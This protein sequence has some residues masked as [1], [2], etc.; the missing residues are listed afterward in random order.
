MS[1]E[2]PRVLASEWGCIL[3]SGESCLMRSC[4][5]VAG[6]S[7]LRRGA[8]WLLGVML[9]SCALLLALWG[10]RMEGSVA[11]EGT[12]PLAGAA[13]GDTS[14]ATDAGS[15]TLAVQ[16]GTAVSHTIFLPILYRPGSLPF[17]VQVNHIESRTTSAAADA[18]A[19]WVRLRLYWDAIEPVNTTPEH[20][21]WSPGL[22]QEL[23]TY[24]ARN[25]NVVLTLAHNPDWAATY[26]AG[27]I[28]LVPIDELVQFM[29]AVVARYGA[30]PY[31]VKHWE[32]YNEP[33]NGD[34]YR[35]E[36]GGWGYFG[37]DPQ[38]YVDL[39]EA[40]Y[41]PVKDVDPEAQVLF[42]GMA[43]DYWEPDGP[44]VKTFFDEVLGIMQDSTSYPFDVMNFHYYP[45]FAV[46]WEAYGADII[47]KTN[48][49]RAKMLE[50]GADKPLVCT[51]T[52]MWSN[53]LDEDF[54]LVCGSDEKQSRYV[55]Q[56]NARSQAAGLEFTVW[57]MLYDAE[58]ATTEYG[59]L[60][61][62]YLPKPSHQA[63][64]TLGR[65]LSQTEYSRTLSLAETGSDQ[66]E[67]YEF[68]EKHGPQRVIVAWTNDELEHPLA[69]PGAS[70][71]KVGK[72]GAETI[73]YDANDGQV[74]G[75]V[76]VIV[77]PSPVYLRV[78]Q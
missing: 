48:F 33:D 27:P 51:E 12:G 10:G 56:V 63:Y 5:L 35:A 59:L 46:N 7:A 58:G 36:N 31:N 26:P 62:D 30:H 25:V 28:D 69:L 17:G 65:Q 60:D 18:R 9:L 39:L 67:A 50:Y 75:Q 45:V 22:D 2:L 32:M 4:F 29:Q 6:W 41:Q 74:D 40:V 11:Q 76:E 77:G 23:A 44:F 1:I 68:L 34:P 43:Y 16:A 38:A 73:L 61:Q 47:G 55:V 8:A 37:D 13:P 66:I 21:T 15:S 64:L 49:I 70:L 14:L 3:G 19:G 72:Y 53:C 54:D 78:A 52:S 24:A 57:F 71:V 20:Y 42:G